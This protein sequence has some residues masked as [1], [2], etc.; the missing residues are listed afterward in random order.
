[1]ADIFTTEKR[2]QIMSLVKGKNTKP[3]M[4]AFKLL[5]RERVHFQRHYDRVPGKPDIAVPSKKLA[6]FIDGAFWHGRDFEDIK[7]KLTPYWRKKIESNVLRD[8]RQKKELRA[9]GW[10]TMRVWEDELRR[11]PEKTLS[12]MRGFLTSR[13]LS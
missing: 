7:H 13:D 9:L 12:K 2:S 1:M 11:N 5:R 3:E 8:R 4:L 6:I 10:K